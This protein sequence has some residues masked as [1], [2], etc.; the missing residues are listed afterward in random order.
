MDCF[1]PEANGD[2]SKE[3]FRRYLVKTGVVHALTGAMV[4]LFTLPEK[5]EDP[6]DF[7]RRQLGDQRPEVEEYEAVLHELGEA[8]DEVE[9]LTDKVAMLKQRLSKYEDVTSEIGED[10]SCQEENN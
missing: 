7:I 9:T 8:K 10:A 6:L 1:G 3:E 5:P 4:M 2:K